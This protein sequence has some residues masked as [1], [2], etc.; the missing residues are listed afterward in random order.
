[1]TASTLHLRSF[2]SAT[3]FPRWSSQ[4]L[5]VAAM[6]VGQTQMAMPLKNLGKSQKTSLLTP[7]PDLHARTYAHAGCHPNSHC[8]LCTY[9][10]IF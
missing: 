4:Q 7:S 5:G 3:V 2:V 1:M 8:H 9:P 10:G 6:P